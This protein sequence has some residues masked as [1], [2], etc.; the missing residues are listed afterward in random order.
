MGHTFKNKNYVLWMVVYAF[1]TFGVQLF[2]SGI[3]EFFSVTGMSMMFVMASSFA[4]V[5]LTLLLYNAITRKFGFGVS[6]AYTLIIY[7]AGMVA[8]YFIGTMAQGAAKTVASIIGGVISSFAIGQLFSVAYSV[9][10]QLAADEE[11]K[12]GISNSAMYFAVQGLFSGVASGIGGTAVLT[13]LKE[14]N[15][16]K[17][18]T[19]LC[20][21][22]MIVALICMI[23][24]PKSVKMMGKKEK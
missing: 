23:F 20:A 22:G 12:T 17:Y 10:A 19:L 8:M 5:P 11:K 6:F 18:M 15:N 9:P 21:A 7:A 16:V 2:L 4:A 24:L 3:N 14:T 13:L 1:M